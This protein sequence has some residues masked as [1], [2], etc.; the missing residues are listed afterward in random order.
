MLFSKV[1]SAVFGVHFSSEGMLPDPLKISAVRDWLQPTDVSKLLQFLGLA[2]YYRKFVN[3]FGEIASPLYRLLEK[4]VQYIW[5]GESQIAFEKLKIALTNSPVLCYISLRSQFVMY[6][7]ASY[8]G[9]GAVLG[10]EGKVLRL[11]LLQVANSKPRR[12]I[13]QLRKSA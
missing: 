13:V 9:L 12:I 1:K 2:S 3:K 4:D 6:T 7:D 10:Q 8:V 5:C 11:F